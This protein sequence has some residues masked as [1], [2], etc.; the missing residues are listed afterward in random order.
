MGVWAGHVAWRGGIPKMAD[1][2]ANYNSVVGIVCSLLH[3]IMMNCEILDHS[4]VSV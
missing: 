3:V 4:Y 2:I 1:M